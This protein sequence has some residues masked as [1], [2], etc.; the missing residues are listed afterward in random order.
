M[1]APL[2]R[3]PPADPLGRALFGLSRAFALAGGVIVVAMT[4]MT[5]VSIA[6]RALLSMPLQGDYELIQLGTAVA[7]AAFL[8]MTQLRGG[9]VIVDFFTA[10]SPASLRARFDALGAL[11][12]G[13]AGAVLAWRMTVG[14]I[15]LQQANDQTTILGFPTWIAV[16]LMVPS[17][18]LLGAAGLYT[19]GL[20]F[21]R[22]GGEEA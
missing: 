14:A 22:R 13:L 7:V 11:L 2:S 4:L 16:A 10:R 12:V 1:D 9:H 5:L 3:R 15:G 19:A 8:P 17:F 20:H 21:A 18:A 6:G